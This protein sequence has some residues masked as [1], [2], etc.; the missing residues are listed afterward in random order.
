MLMTKR[1]ETMQEALEKVG[2]APNTSMFAGL[3]FPEFMQ[4][5]SESQNAG[6]RSNA[7]MSSQFTLQGLVDSK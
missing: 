7:L 2:K 3:H 6:N 4:K 1:G 5:P